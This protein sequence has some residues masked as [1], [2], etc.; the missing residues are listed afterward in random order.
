MKADMHVHSVRSDG[1]FTAKE[2]AR[3]AAENGVQ[4]LCI[5]DH[6]NFGGYG[7]KRAA[8]RSAG[9]VSVPGVEISAYEGKI[10]LHLT[11]YGFDPSAPR[12]GAIQRTLTEGARE[13]MYDTLFRL[14]KYKGY[15]LNENEIYAQQRAEG[16]VHTMHVVRALVSR[17]YYPDVTAAFRDCFI[18]GLPTYSFV[19]RP[20][21]EWAIDALHSLGGIICIAH[22][23]RIYLAAEEKEKTIRRLVKAGVDGMECF[24]SSHT[25]RE[26]EY[27]LRL[28]E[29]LGIL[30]SGGSDFHAD[31]SGR[32]IGVPHFEPSQAFLRAVR[33]H[34]FQGDGNE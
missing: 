16:P 13:R 21:P 10:K 27:F 12:L 5:T 9:I 8:L 23:G 25:E 31:G 18:P 7:Q 26:T 34:R 28:A 32:T 29:E 1:E 4:L 20:T 14:K 11:G 15:A 24:Y 6:D 33:F 30:V 17:G 19:G 2:L 3:R 22:P